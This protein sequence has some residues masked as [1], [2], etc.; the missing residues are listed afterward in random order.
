MENLIHKE[1]IIRRRM[2]GKLIVYSLL[3]IMSVSFSDDIQQE[4]AVAVAV[5]T[6][7]EFP[8]LGERSSTP[9]NQQRG[10][11]S[12]DPIRG[13][14]SSAD[15]PALATAANTN[16]T[17][18]RGIWREQ[19]QQQGTSSST[20]PNTTSKKVSQ[21]VK[22]VTNG[23]TSMNI[24]EDFPALRG[25]NNAKIPAHVS[26]FSAWSTAKKSSKNANGTTNSEL[27]LT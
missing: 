23:A 27:L 12:T 26:M 17:Q 24:R 22:P 15:F 7:D 20:A 21:P 18:P 6:I 25:A 1:I 4:P 13:I 10:A 8:T 14:H 11:W 19:Q 3:S 16:T 5:P 9:Q 2:N